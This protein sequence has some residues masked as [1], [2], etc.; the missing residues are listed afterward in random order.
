[1][2]R[3][4]AISRRARARLRART[5]D[6][7]L[8]SHDSSTNVSLPNGNTRNARRCG[9]R[10]RTLSRPFAAMTSCAGSATRRRVDHGR[11]GCPLRRY[12]RHRHRRREGVRCNRATR[13]RGAPAPPG[14]PC[15]GERRTNYSVVVLRY[16]YDYEF[17]I[18]SSS[19]CRKNYSRA[20][21]EW[22]APFPGPL[23]RVHVTAVDLM[24]I[25]AHPARIVAGSSTS[26]RPRARRMKSRCIQRAGAAA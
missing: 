19:R 25:G 15:G 5:S 26:M 16:R 3:A 12:P 4:R 10:T 24:V 6:T 23:L 7:Q 2:A 17:A 13:G 18:R 20:L 8:N 14:V 21:A 1:M 11:Q 22:P 9:A